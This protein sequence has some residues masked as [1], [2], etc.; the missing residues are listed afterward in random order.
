MTDASSIQVGHIVSEDGTRVG[1]RKLGTGPA[2]VLIHGSLADGEEYLPFA[3]ALSA[4]FT[5]WVADSR[6]RGLSGDFPAN[7][8]PQTIVQDH[9]ALVREAGG[10]VVLFGH[11]FGATSVLLSAVEVS[12]FVGVVAYEPPLP[13]N[14]VL[15]SEI[16]AYAASLA[17]GDTDGAVA[18]AFTN[19]VGGSLEDLE[20]VRTTPVWEAMKA[21]APT[22]VPE[23]RLLDALPSMPD[24]VEK[25]H[26]PLLAI[27]GGLSPENLRQSTAA[28]AETAQAGSLVEMA[29]ID[30]SGHLSDPSGMAQR[31]VEWYRTTISS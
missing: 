8:G 15:A 3:S 30:H 28:V 31:V 19:I 18:R 16:N 17:A 1:F 20:F 7:Y 21:I 25:I 26:A 10:D 5:V 24:Q 27:R 9:Q 11:S 23:L 29:H 4:D 2:L 22:F 13:P 12:G 14:G 6:G